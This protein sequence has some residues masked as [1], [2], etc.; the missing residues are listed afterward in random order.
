MSLP[1]HNVW[2][3]STIPNVHTS[4]DYIPPNNATDDFQA[5]VEDSVYALGRAIREIID[6]R[7][8]ESLA[9]LNTCIESN[10]RAMEAFEKTVRGISGGGLQ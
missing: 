5:N 4:E 1:P 6:D 8:K 7:F 10:T 9:N 2:G 3:V